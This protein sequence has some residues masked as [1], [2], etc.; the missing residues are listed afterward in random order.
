M[1]FECRIDLAAVSFAYKISVVACV[2]MVFEHAKASRKGPVRI[3]QQT[4]DKVTGQSKFIRIVTKKGEKQTV[5][6]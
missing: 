3:S 1:C 2:V 4:E 6:G 5:A